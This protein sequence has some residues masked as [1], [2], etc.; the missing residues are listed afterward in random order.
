MTKSQDEY[1]L[2]TGGAGYIGSHTCRL[3]ALKGYTPVTYDNLSTGNAWAVNWGPLVEADILDSA[4]LSKTIKKYE[5]KTIIHF[6]AKAYV[7]ESI[8]APISYYRNNVA[9]TISVLEAAKRTGI[10]NFIFSS[11]CAV[12]GK[13]ERVPVT[14]DTP[15]NPISPYGK[16]KA[17][18]EQIIRD[19]CETHG[20]KYALLRYFNAAGA[21][22]ASGIGECHEPETHLIPRAIIAAL[23]K[24]PFCL[25]GINHPTKDGTCIR[26]YIH[27]SDLAEAHI[28][29]KSALESKKEAIIANIGTGKGTSIKKII[30]IIEQKLERKLIIKQID[31]RPGDPPAIYARANQRNKEI[32]WSPKKSN[33]QKII[34][35]A[36]EWHLRH[37]E[38]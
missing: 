20:I 38:T 30:E 22:P 32:N 33:T 4:K 2:V 37:G 31:R 29:A 7:G 36:I 11:S 6:A 15:I 9:G 5:S 14:E 25:N 35:D 28:S 18:S 12:Y 19:A 10:N 24:E 26:D 13:P 21:E 17:M 8:A 16:T 3:L 23:T 34:E 27:V 1:I